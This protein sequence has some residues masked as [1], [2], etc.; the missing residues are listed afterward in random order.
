M[1]CLNFHISQWYLCCLLCFF[2][3]FSIS[4]NV[5]SVSL[6][7]A[8]FLL[9]DILHDHLP[10]DWTCIC[11]SGSKDYQLVTWSR[12]QTLRIWRVDPQLQRVSVEPHRERSCLVSTPAS[13]C[14][15]C[16]CYCAAVRQ[17]RR[18]GPD[19]VPDGGV[20]EDPVLSGTRQ[21]PGH[22]PNSGPPAG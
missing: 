19:G 3:Y 22:W 10:D 20:G 1:D 17:R 12:D 7:V 9:H 11:F 14:C 15:S 4:G 18:G 21:S 8:V 2:N 16:R 5:F 6:S 13:S